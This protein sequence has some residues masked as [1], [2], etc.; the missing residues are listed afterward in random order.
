VLDTTREEL[1]FVQ[2]E[3]LREFGRAFDFERYFAE[4]A[5]G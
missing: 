2:D 4:L 1:T 3:W 5:A